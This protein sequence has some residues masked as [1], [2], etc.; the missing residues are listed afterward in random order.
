MTKDKWKSEKTDSLVPISPFDTQNELKLKFSNTDEKQITCLDITYKST[1]SVFLNVIYN[2]M[3]GSKIKYQIPKSDTE[4]TFTTCVSDLTYQLSENFTIS[5]IITER[6]VKANDF[7]ITKIVQKYSPDTI[8]SPEIL[9][10]NWLNSTDLKIKNL[11][12]HAA[13]IENGKT[14]TFKS[15]L[16]FRIFFSLD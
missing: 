15:E 9:I 5:L 4:Q 11:N 3:P 10:Q 13:K 7:T 8:K 6:E 12:E 2:E 16:F 14:L 1:K